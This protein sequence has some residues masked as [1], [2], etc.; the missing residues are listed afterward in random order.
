MEKS[1]VQ[2]DVD[3]FEQSKPIPIPLSEK[4]SETDL[5]PPEQ[6]VIVTR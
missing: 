3:M 5:L 1:F 4:K 2:T 6:E